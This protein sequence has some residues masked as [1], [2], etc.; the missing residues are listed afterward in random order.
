MGKIRKSKIGVLTYLEPNIPIANEGVEE[1]K[2]V[3]EECFLNNEFKIILNFHYVPYIDS[4]GLEML[5]QILEEARKKGG[6]IKIAD[7]NPV[8][9]DILIATRLNTIF[10]IYPGQDQAGRS[11]L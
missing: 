3:I 2:E 1:L 4:K 8:C 11:F 6:S 7:P 10:E 9:Q 5:L